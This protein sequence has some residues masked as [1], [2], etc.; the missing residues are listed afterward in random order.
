[1]RADASGMDG[2]TALTAS[3]TS[4]QATVDDGVSPSVTIAPSPVPWSALDLAFELTATDNDHGSGVQSVTVQIDG[5]PLTAT[6]G[7]NVSISLTT[8]GSHT[9]SFFATDRAGNNS[10][11]QA[12][13]AGI[14]RTAPTI[15]GSQSP[16]AVGGWNKSAVTVRFTCSDSLSGVR[17]CSGPVALAGETAGTSIPGTA[18]DNAGNSASTS[19]G[20]VRIDLTA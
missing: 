18:V 14:D 20:P 3:G 8:E 9:V 16:P 13:T 4:A 12:V 1:F 2:G 17:T 5:G 10:T 15:A 6:N 19:W 7:A 11:T